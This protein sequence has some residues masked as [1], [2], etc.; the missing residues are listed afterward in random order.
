M[1]ELTVTRPLRR[2]LRYAAMRLR[3]LLIVFVAAPLLAQSADERYW[4]W[5]AGIGWPAAVGTSQSAANG[6]M[7]TMID[8]VRMR[9]SGLGF[10]IDGEFD[11]FNPNDRIVKAY[12]AKGGRA[13]VYSLSFDI[14]HKL[15]DIGW[16]YTYLFGGVGTHYKQTYL[17]NP[18]NGAICDPFWGICYPTGSQIVKSHTD[19]GY[20]ANGGI[21]YQVPLTNESQLFIELK[22]QWVNTKATGA[23]WVP[24]T[25]GAR[26]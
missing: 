26:F 11:A 2:R 18:S 10:R 5:G 16:G 20:G 1:A 24:I 19:T 22:Y 17:D 3:M 6:L 25:I 4:Q 9:P 13:Q 14:E 8:A 12:G 7:H 21:G 23:M 15:G